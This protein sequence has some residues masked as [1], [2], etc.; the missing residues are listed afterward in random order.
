MPSR[1]LVIGSC[2]VIALGATSAWAQP[3][4][5]KDG[6]LGMKFVPLPNDP[7]K[8]DLNALRGEWEVDWIEAVGRRVEWRK[9]VLAF[10]GKQRLTRKH[11]DTK[12]EDGGSL[13]IDPTCTPKVIDF[14]NKD[15]RKEGI[16]KLEGDTMLWCVYE[17]PGKNRPLEF[18]AGPDSRN[19]LIKLSRIKVQE[20]G[21]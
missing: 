20:K 21:D 3:P 1:Y 12:Y 17:G 10:R 4:A 8:K 9:G 18:R 13:E 6:P 19:V 16:Y 5:R 7:V 14:I 11:G 2:L 15:G